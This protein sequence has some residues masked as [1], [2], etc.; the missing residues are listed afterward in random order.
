VALVPLA[1]KKRLSDC[2]VRDMRG[3]DESIQYKT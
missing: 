3:L 2:R 1:C